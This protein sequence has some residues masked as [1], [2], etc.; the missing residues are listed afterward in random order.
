MIKFFKLLFLG[1]KT[2]NAIAML[3]TDPGFCMLLINGRG[4]TISGCRF[5]P[6]Y[7]MPDFKALAAEHNAAYRKKLSLIAQ[8]V[9]S[10]GFKST[11]ESF[12]N[13]KESS[14]E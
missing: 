13:I 6:P 1:R 11:N 12:P 3:A 9:E 4:V 2:L 5:Y 10:L 7:K 14:D 8:L